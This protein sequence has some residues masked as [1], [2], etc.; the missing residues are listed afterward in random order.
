VAGQLEE[1]VKEALTQSNKDKDARLQRQSS[2]TQ[3][4]I[5]EM[6]ATSTT[7]SATS[8]LLTDWWT[9]MR[10]QTRLATRCQLEQ[11]R[12]QPRRI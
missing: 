9:P 11:S 12:I 5:D 1:D 2:F 8:D 10:A 6:M 7:Q 4:D 3:E